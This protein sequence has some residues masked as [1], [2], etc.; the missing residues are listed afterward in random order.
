MSWLGQA[1]A[2]HSQAAINAVPL[3]GRNPLQNPFKSPRAPR[4]RRIA[5]LTTLQAPRASSRRT[6]V[7]QIPTPGKRGGP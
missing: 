4:R 3:P 2:P 5:P 1:V 6:G 7:R